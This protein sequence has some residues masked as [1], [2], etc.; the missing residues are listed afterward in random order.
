MTICEVMPISEA[1][2]K[3]IIDPHFDLDELRLLARKEGMVTMIEDG[4]RKVELGLTTI[5]EVFRIIRE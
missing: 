2:R 1:I 4:L 3:L 5:E